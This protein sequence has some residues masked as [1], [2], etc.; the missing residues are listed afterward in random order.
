MGV[1]GSISITD[2]ASGVLKT[3]RK[4]QS[5]FKREVS[6]TG[7]Q[8]NR[9]WGKTYQAKVETKTAAGKISTLIGKAKQAG[10]TAVTP[11]VR[12]KDKATSTISK[13]NNKVKALGKA[14]GSA[15]C[16][17]KGCCYQ[18]AGNR[19]QEAG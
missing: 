15:C 14:G 5:A 13:I 9:T 6:E 19:I 1:V 7:K 3:I 2:R 18:S 8:L 17:S 12:V 10:K 16:E 11:V 4:E